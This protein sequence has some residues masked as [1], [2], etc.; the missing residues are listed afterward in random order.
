MQRLTDSLQNLSPAQR[1]Q[2]RQIATA[3][4]ALLLVIFIAVIAFQLGRSSGLSRAQEAATTAEALRVSMAETFTPTP[5]TT[6]TETPAPTFT[7]TLTATPT[8]TPASP[9]EWA[10]RYFNLA[11]QGLN[12]LAAL[13]FTPDRAAALVERL[14]HEQGLVF[15]PSSY[16]RLAGESYAA[17][18]APRTPDGVALSMLFWQSEETGNQIE[19]Q[20]LLDALPYSL[21]G[22]APLATGIRLGAMGVDAQGIRYMLL[23]ERPG[24]QARLTAHLWSQTL[25]GAPFEVRWRSEEDA[26]WSFS[27]ADSEVWLEAR[28][29]SVLPDLW[30]ASPLPADSAIRTDEG[31]AGIFIEQSPFAQQRLQTRWQ[32]MLASDVAPNAPPRIVGYRLA[33]AEVQPTPLSAMATILGWLQTGQ[34]TRAQTLVARIDLLNDMFDLGLATPGDWMAVYVNEMDREIQDSAIS[35]RLRFFDNADRNRSFEAVFA[36]NPETGRYVLQSIAP[37]LLASSAG[38]VTPA[39]P[40]PTPSPTE[41]AAALLATTGEFTLTVPLGDDVAEGAALLNPTLEPTSTPTPTFT[42]TPTDTPTVTSTP[43]PTSPPTDTPTPT[44][45]PTF[46]PTPTPTE[47]PLPIPAIPP[48]AQPPLTGYML[49]TDTGR[50][51]G[52]PGTDYI[53]I[54]GLQNGTPVDIFGITEAGDW[55]LIRAATVNDGRTNVLGWVATQLVIPYGDYGVVPR[56]RADGSSVDAPPEEEA[57]NDAATLANLP[58]ATATPTPLVTPV[59]RLPEVQIQPSGNVPAPEQDEQVVTIGG[60]VIP[61]DALAPIPATTSNGAAIQIDSRDAVIEIWSA[62]VG[63]TA[64][65]WAPANAALLWPGTVA[66][67]SVDPATQANESATLRATRVRIVAAPSV[68]RVKELS[69]PEIAAATASNTAIALL[70]S[71]NAPGLYLL[72]REGRAQQ[73]WQYENTVGW[74]SSDPNAGFIVTEPPTAGGLSTFSWMRKDGRGLQIIAQPYRTIRGVAGDA[75]GGLWWIETPNAAVDLWQLWHYEPATARI[76]LR[77]QASGALFARV[78]GREGASLAPTLSAVQ[79]VTPGDPSSAYLFVDTSDTTLQQPFTGFFR[80]RLETDEEGRGAIVE[81]PQLLLESGAYRGPLA[82]SP[83]LTRLA[84]FA[85]DPGQPSLTS[86]I[87]RPANTVNVLTLSGRGASIIRAAYVTETRFEFLAPHIAWSGTDRLIL[88]RGRFVAGET[89]E[90][91]WFGLVQVQL[92]SPGS[93]P[94]DPIVASSYLLPRQQSARDFAACLDQ[95]WILVLTRDR[96]GAQQLMRWNGQNQI[97][98][99]FGLPEALD[100]TFLCWQP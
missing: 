6:A 37:V 70:G 100:R 97:F 45:T 14:A 20:L 78:G 39:P 19:G 21:A 66:Y 68:E 43:S 60:S 17:F 55:L 69:L 16:Y 32:P 90:Q 47:K 95:A 46:T 94:A 86:G 10:E 50:L 36:L 23:V 80:M 35:T 92:P 25:P 77:L 8:A 74:L 89:A 11:M 18:V 54:A 83:D 12:T 26:Q 65:S 38:L 2:L 4:V 51:R 72:E 82:L 34:V 64:G 81:G 40:R 85:Y 99:I 59:I 75:Y 61:P 58:T 49:L 63:E 62:I 71:R 79:L 98:P 67:L 33:Q 91:D 88:A 27:A 13:D 96:D 24:S 5:S 52:G 15:V 84:F 42:P 28:S 93:S 3:L 48:E 31:A 22:G 44:P 41:I 57:S 87:L 30:I 56:H 29:D 7:P 53:V 9:A 1:R 73:L 76:A